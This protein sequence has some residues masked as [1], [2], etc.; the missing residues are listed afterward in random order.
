MVMRESIDPGPQA[1][2]L[3]H[4]ITIHAYTVH[5]IPDAKAEDAA[6]D[7]LDQVLMS[8]QRLDVLT[9]VTAKRVVLAD[10]FQG[11]T[12]TAEWLSNDIYK[13]QVHTER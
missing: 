1:N 7:L 3:A 10:K 8:L 5:S 9:K 2:S 6:D 11:W 12:I 13:T 4:G